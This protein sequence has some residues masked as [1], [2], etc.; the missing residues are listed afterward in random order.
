MSEPV[1]G[2]EAEFE[3]WYQD[4]HLPELIVLD[5][6]V[7]AQRYRRVRVLGA[8]QS[9]PH[10]AVYEIETDDIDAVIDG[11]ILV[12]EAGKLT[13]SEAIDT[14]LTSAAVFEP[15]ARVVSG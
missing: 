5:G 6:F 9:W 1:P 3:R 10:M 4:V 15:C 8:A 2:R 13:L 14:D 11:L 7:A 12:A